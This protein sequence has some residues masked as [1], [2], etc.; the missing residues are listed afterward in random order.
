MGVTTPV[1]P[2]P[3]VRRRASK[4]LWAAGVIVAALL[5]LFLAQGLGNA[6]LYFRTASEAA[7]QRTSLGTKR[8]RI[9]GVVVNG[10]VKRVGQ[11]VNFTI[12]DG[13]VSVPVHHRGD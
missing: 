12:E 5:G 4:G 8:F 2:A 6:T 10:S 7:K 1:P 11:D 3:R 9:E 13:D